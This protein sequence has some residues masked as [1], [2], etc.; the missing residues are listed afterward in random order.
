MSL[1]AGVQYLFRFFA[2]SAYHGVILLIAGQILGNIVTKCLCQWF[3]LPIGV[4]GT[5]I[6]L[7]VTEKAIAFKSASPLVTGD[8]EVT[9]GIHAPLLLPFWIHPRS[10]YNHPNTELEIHGLRKVIHTFGE[11]FPSLPVFNSHEQS[12]DHC[13]SPTFAGGLVVLRY[14]STAASVSRSWHSPSDRFESSC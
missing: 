6:W 11:R 12:F 5:E 7:L 2:D 14:S 8:S 9:M 3:L 4:F 10:Q 1:V 13:L